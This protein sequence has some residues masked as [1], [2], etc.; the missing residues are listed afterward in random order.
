MRQHMMLRTE[1]VGNLGT[2]CYLLCNKDTKEAI[3]IDPG[4]QGH[5]IRD[6]LESLGMQLTA[7]LL[8]H[9]HYDHIGGVDALKE[10]YINV[11]VYASY[12]EREILFNEEDN[13][14]A[15]LGRPCTVDADIYLHDDDRLELIG[16]HFRVIHTPGH[17]PGGLCFYSIDD[18]VLFSG[19]TLFAGSVGRTD[20]PGGDGEELLRSVKERLSIIPDY[21]KVYPG[22]GPSTTMEIEREENPYM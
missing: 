12:E 22:H 21:V 17:T 7:I 11:K 8:T 3:V 6:V 2:N 1:Q 10:S 15:M 14:S 4:A 20:F 5:L 19:D 16:T 9:G 13:L 18:E